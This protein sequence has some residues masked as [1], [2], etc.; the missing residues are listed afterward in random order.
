ML[1]PAVNSRSL[2]T[3]RTR[4]P[5]PTRPAPTSQGG[6]G[7]EAVAGRTRLREPQRPRSPLQRYRGL[8]L[9]IGAA[10]IVVVVG[11]VLFLGASSTAYACTTVLQPAAPAT[12]APGQSPLLGQVTRDLGRTHVDVGTSVTYEFCPPTSGAHYNASRLGP[13]PALFYGKDDATVPEGWIHNMEHG[14]MVVLYRCPEGCG[15]DAQTSLAAL[16]GQ[17]PASPI[18]GFPSTTNVV[19]TR[20][21]QMPTPYAAVVWGRVL[22]LN[23]LDVGAITTF[24][25][26]SGDQGPEPWCQQAMPGYT[27]SPGPSASPTA[28]PAPTATP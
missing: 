16:Q 12:A 11:G 20:F 18:C 26:Q 13:I 10:A 23:S 25:A 1:V 9:G 22:F 14:G 27:P 5:Q 6:T 15:A 2:V 7:A 21:D 4:N 24:Y 3:K 8:L 17:L 19:V 28:S